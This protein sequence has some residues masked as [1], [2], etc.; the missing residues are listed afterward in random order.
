MSKFVDASSERDY[1]ECDWT[2][3]ASGSTDCG[4]AFQWES[5]NAMLQRSK[6]I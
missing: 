2:Q 6:R 4:S 1:K 5:R 3:S